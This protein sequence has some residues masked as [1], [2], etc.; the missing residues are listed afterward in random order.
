MSGHWESEGSG[1]SYRRYWVEDVEE[2]IVEEPQGEPVSALEA[3]LL[4]EQTT[5][6]AR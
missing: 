6:P 5:V 2:E 4:A 3:A 1:C